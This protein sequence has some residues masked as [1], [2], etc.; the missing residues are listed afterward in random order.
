MPIAHIRMKPQRNHLENLSAY[1]ERISEMLIRI[2][3]IRMANSRLFL[4]IYKMESEDYQTHCKLWFIPYLKACH[5]CP[6]IF[7]SPYNVNLH[8]RFYNFYTS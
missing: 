1:A 2:G 5:E 3:G 7:F 8:Y 4:R 6:S